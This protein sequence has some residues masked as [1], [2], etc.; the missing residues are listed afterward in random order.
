[1]KGTT[2]KDIKA[3]RQHRYSDKCVQCGKHL[4]QTDR[5]AAHMIAYP[6]AN[7]CCGWVIL[8]TTCKACNAT[9]SSKKHK[10]KNAFW[11]CSFRMHRLRIFCCMKPISCS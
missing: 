6:C 8:R 1:M 7:Y 9:R 10:Y 11:G 5:V 3:R 2:G 4:K